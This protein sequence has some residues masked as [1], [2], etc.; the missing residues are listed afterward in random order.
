M[1][2]LLSI[3]VL[4][5]IGANVSHA[6]CTSCAIQ[7]DEY[8]DFCFTDD[9]FPEYCAQF[10]D[11]RDVF[12]LAKGKK[13]RLLPNENEFGDAYYLQIANNRKLKLSALEMLFVQQAVKTWTVER[14][15]YSHTY[16]A[17][18]LGYKIIKEGTGE[19]PQAGEQVAVHYTGYL[20]NGE[21]F[22]S[23]YDRDRP[24]TF[25]LGQGQ[26]I[27]GWDEGVA[28]LKKG[29][30]AVL[31][32]P[33]DLAYGPIKRGPIPANATLFFEIELLEQ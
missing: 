23:S 9:N 5:L 13:I 4:L 12:R 18:G 27:K 28:L 26:V 2:Y 25:A 33:P 20:E 19:I 32:I 16:T 11:K 31:R 24:F 1:K 8:S 14:R 21:R 7:Q 10:S 15:K 30:K 17:S 3:I 29:S 22:D 6:Q